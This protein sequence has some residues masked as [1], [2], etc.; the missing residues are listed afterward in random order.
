MSRRIRVYG[1]LAIVALLLGLNVFEHFKPSAHLAPV[2]STSSPEVQNLPSSSAPIHHE[3]GTASAF[4][5]SDKP[6]VTNSTPAALPRAWVTHHDPF[7]PPEPVVAPP[8]V[9]VVKAP[10]PPPPPAPVVIP[11]QQPY[12]V[13]GRIKGGEGEDYVYL[14]KGNALFLA[15]PNTP[16][17]DG[18]VV[19]QIQATQI[20]LVHQPGGEQFTLS[21][22]GEDRSLKPSRL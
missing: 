1:G 11:I 18:F 15:R 13:L 19:S 3:R 16:L 22:P 7:W 17:E 21:L 12:T 2:A 14:R 9:K 20:H 5:P 10:P 8:K 4:V 6:S